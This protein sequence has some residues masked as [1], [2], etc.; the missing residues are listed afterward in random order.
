MPLPAPEWVAFAPKPP[1]RWGRTFGGAAKHDQATAEARRAYDERVA[2]H[3]AAESDRRQQLEARRVAYEEQAA[4]APEAVELHNAA[5]DEFE[6]AVYR[7]EGEPVAL[8]FTL[9]LDAAV[10]PD[11]FPHR[12]RVIYDSEPRHLVIDFELPTQDLV[13][14]DREYR[15]V[16]SHDAIETIPR[17]VREVRDQY[18]QLISQ[19]SLRTVHTVFRADPAELL[20]KVTFNGR[21][22]TIDKATGQAIRPHL[23]TVTTTKKALA[24]L[25]LTELD[26]VVCLRHLDAVVSR[27]PYDLDAVRPLVDFEA[28]LARYTC[29]EGMDAIATLDRRPDLLAMS[30]TEFEHF[31]KQLFE[32]MGMKSWVTQAS[33]DDGVDAVATNEDPVFGGLC[34]IQAKRCS[35]V[36]DVESVRALA[37]VMEDKH[38]TKGI[39]VATSWVDPAGH[40]FTQRHGRIEII[41]GR[42]LKHLCRDHLD[43]LISIPKPPP[44]HRRVDL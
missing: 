43:V 25:V 5:V 27:H 40:A 38:A 33:K 4:T 14:L 3:A 37:D 6:A 18:A 41:E 16:Q 26:P 44:R 17:T 7:S 20:G 23:I 11:G 32:E 29:V 30:P 35:G 34:I 21:V 8:F 28:M 24:D 2:G 15:Y 36:V 22:E 42:H 13:P 19:V 31:I 39:L 10:Y 9:V 12:T 1:S